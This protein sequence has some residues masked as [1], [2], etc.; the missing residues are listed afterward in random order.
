M[1]WDQEDATVLYD[2]YIFVG[3]DRAFTPDGYR[4]GCCR[5]KRSVSLTQQS[6]ITCLEI[7]AT[8]QLNVTVIGDFKNLNREV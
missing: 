7:L 1:Q 6:G 3:Q 2:L 5:E 4:V 8:Y